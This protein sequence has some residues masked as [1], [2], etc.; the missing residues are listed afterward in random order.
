VVLAVDGFHE[1]VIPRQVLYVG[2]SRARDLLVVV[3]DPDE[4]EAAVG[5]AVMKRLREAAR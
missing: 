5:P 1:H 4:I 3:G 2:M